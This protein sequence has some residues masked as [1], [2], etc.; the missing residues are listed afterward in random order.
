MR[1]DVDNDHV[2]AKK[3]ERCKNSFSTV[4]CEIPV[5]VRLLS[6]LWFIGG[7]SN[8][9]HNPPTFRPKE[10]FFSLLTSRFVSV[11]F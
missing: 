9:Y 11:T 6:R 3:V 8:T 7:P 10:T 1:Y 5:R 2:T 4:G